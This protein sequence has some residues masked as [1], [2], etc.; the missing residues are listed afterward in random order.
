[1]FSTDEPPVVQ[2]VQTAPIEIRGSFR[3][4]EEFVR[5]APINLMV[6]GGG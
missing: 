1:V 6:G 2:Q 3:M 5:N 4:V